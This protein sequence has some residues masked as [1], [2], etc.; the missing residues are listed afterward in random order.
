MKHGLCI[1]ESSHKFIWDMS[2]RKKVKT[3]E[4]NLFTF[5]FSFLVL[6][7]MCLGCFPL[8]RQEQITRGANK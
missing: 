7:F 4:R 2:E 5:F 6:I 3:K 8:H 1:E